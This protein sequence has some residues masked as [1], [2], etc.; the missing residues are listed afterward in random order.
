[1]EIIGY[2]LYMSSSLIIKHL[3]ALEQAL[4]LVERIPVLTNEKPMPGSFH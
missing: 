1:M 4:L 3:T 2:L